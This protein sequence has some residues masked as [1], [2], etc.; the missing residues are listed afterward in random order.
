MQ[1]ENPRKTYIYNAH[2]HAL[3]GHI[4]RPLDQLIEVQAGMSLPA[5]GGHGSSRVENFRFNQFVS[6]KCGH[7]TVS[8]SKSEEDGSH[9]TL[10]TSAVEGLNVLDV[11]TADRLVTRIASN[12]KLEDA[13]AKI[14]V[15]GSKIDNLTIAG[16]KVHV[17][18]DDELFLR[19]NT[20]EAL[21]KEFE[22][23]AGFRKMAG[24]PF[25]PGQTPKTIQAHGVM[26][27]SLV[28]DMKTTCPGV[29]RQGHAFDIPEFGRVFVGEVFAQHSKRTVTML[30][31]EL[32]CPVAGAMS[33]AQGVGN[34]TTWP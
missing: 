9:T 31:F 22:S 10:V 26:L 32:G 34:G 19:L 15:L 12:H 13:E 4:K 30:R 14:T 2:G 21:R 16:C 18:F 28:K 5:I 25:Q 20:F 23:N 3:S 29:K 6:F 33:A 11:V 17:E 24:D 27:C 1:K 7:T 8:G